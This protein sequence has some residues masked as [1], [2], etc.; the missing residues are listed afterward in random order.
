MVGTIRFELATPK[1]MNR[2][3]SIGEPEQEDGV[4]LHAIFDRWDSARKPGS[5]WATEGSGTFDTWF[6]VRMGRRCV[7]IGV[8][9]ERGNI[10]SRHSGNRPVKPPA[11][12]PV[13][14]AWL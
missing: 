4:E 10:R 3:M 7:S 13:K 5:C 8:R 9:A 12:P 14:V 2:G 11:R 1:P 6:W